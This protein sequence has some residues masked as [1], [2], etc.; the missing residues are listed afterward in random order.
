MVAINPRQRHATSFE[1]IGGRFAGRH[2]LATRDAV[3]T[4]TVGTQ[5]SSSVEVNLRTKAPLETIEWEDC[6]ELQWI[7]QKDISWQAIAEFERE[8]AESVGVHQSARDRRRTLKRERPT[9]TSRRTRARVALRRQ[10]A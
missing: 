1:R 9:R 6:D 4:V 5:T 7:P 2:L 3:K 8:Y 10:L